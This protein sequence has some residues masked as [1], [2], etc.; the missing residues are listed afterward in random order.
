MSDTPIGIDLS[1][2]KIDQFNQNMQDLYY[3]TRP[4]YEECQLRCKILNLV[5]DIWQTYLY[6][7]ELDAMQDEYNKRY[8]DI[9]TNKSFVELQSIP[10]PKHHNKPYRRY[11]PTQTHNNNKPESPEQSEQ[12]DSNPNRSTSTNDADSNNESSSKEQEIFSGSEEKV[13]ESNASG[14]DKD[15]DK[16]DN[17]DKDKDEQFNHWCTPIEGEEKVIIIREY[18]GGPIVKRV[19]IPSVMIFGSIAFGLDGFG[20]D[21]DLALPASISNPA[22]N[23]HKDTNYQSKLLKAFMS[24]FNLEMKK[25]SALGLKW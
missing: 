12:K 18:E 6:E 3:T 2:A 23:A 14:S 1:N 15:G 17:K 16:D 4:E 24:R 25:S 21:I 19:I 8:R 5:N 9:I 13:S 10:N 20:S 22:V 11:G 7:T